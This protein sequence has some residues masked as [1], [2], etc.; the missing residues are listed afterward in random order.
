MSAIAEIETITRAQY[1]Q[2]QYRGTA[3]PC[4][5]LD[6]AELLQRW[7]SQFPDWRRRYWTLRVEDRDALRLHPVNL[8]PRR[9]T[10]HSV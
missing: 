7:R 3:G 6:D 1:E 2:R 4:T 10:A 5:Q 9:T 8:A